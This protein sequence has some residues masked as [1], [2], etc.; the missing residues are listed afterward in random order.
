MHGADLSP[1][2]HASL[3]VRV[4]EGRED[5]KKEIDAFFFVPNGAEL[6]LTYDLPFKDFNEAADHATSLREEGTIFHVRR[7]EV[8]VVR[9]VTE[10]ECL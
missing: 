2:P 9:N 8:A 7:V 3:S 1:P 6:D 10:V 5:M 4:T